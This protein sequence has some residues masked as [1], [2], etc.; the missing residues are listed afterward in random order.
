MVVVGGSWVSAKRL[1]SAEWHQT[2]ILQTDLEA[3]T[4]Q[5]RVDESERDFKNVIWIIPFVSRSFLLI[6][7]P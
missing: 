3:K 2:N 5:K 7:A 6:G 1:V 4:K